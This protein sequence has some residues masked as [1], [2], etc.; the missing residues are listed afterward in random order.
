MA[1]YGSGLS[2]KE[3]SALDREQILHALKGEMIGGQGKE[4]GVYYVPIDKKVTS[5]KEIILAAYDEAVFQA[6]SAMR[7]ANALEE[8]MEAHGIHY[9]DI[10]PEYMK[11]I[12]QKEK[13]ER[14]E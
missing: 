4:E 6:K 8:V 10:F 1:R 11:I 14:E 12:L 3:A 5:A 9:E 7:S 13:A 2:F